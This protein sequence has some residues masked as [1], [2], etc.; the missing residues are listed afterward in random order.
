MNT[1]HGAVPGERRVQGSGFRED[2][3]RVSK[4]IPPDLRH[5]RIFWPTVKGIRLR[6]GVK[7]IRL[8]VGVKG[9]RLRVGVK[10]IRLRVAVKGIRLRVGVK[11]SS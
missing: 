9:I 3:M 5:V 2:R 10:G 1:E 7:G 8:R 11:G 4:L 6:V